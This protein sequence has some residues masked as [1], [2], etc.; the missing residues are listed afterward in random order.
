MFI[1]FCAGWPFYLWTVRREILGRVV[2]SY[3]S[4][5]V[6]YGIIRLDRSLEDCI[7]VA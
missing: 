1:A 4:C 7:W 6:W 2:K 5:G 3:E